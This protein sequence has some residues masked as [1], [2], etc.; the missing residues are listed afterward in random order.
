MSI[1]Q[2]LRD[3]YL[4]LTVV[5]VILALLGFLLMDS[6]NSN[7][8][9]IMG[10]GPGKIATVNGD[11]ITREE[12]EQGYANAEINYKEQN[13]DADMD[14]QTIEQLR[15]NVI[16]E[17]IRNKLLEEEY[18]KAD[19]QVSAAE[20]KY[21]MT[22]DNAS[23][24]LKQVPAFIN[25][26]T[27]QFDGNLVKEY[28]RNVNSKANPQVTEEDRRRWNEFKAS[29]LQERRMLKY[30]AL[31]AN[32]IYVPTYM[33]VDQ[34]QDAASVARAEL[35]TIPYD[36]IAAADIKV[37]DAEINE[38]I[39]NHKEQFRVRE[40]GRNAEYVMFK[41][42]PS[43]K[44]S[45]A[46]NTKMNTKLEAFKVASD[47]VAYINQN[48]SIPFT[49]EYK[50]AKDLDNPMIAGA[51][52]G[53]IVGPF[54]N[55]NMVT[56]SKIIATKQ[57]ADSANAQHILL[58]GKEGD[59][60]ES[61]QARADSIMG[62]IRSG[63]L[64]FGDAAAAF[65]SDES[66][67]AKAGDL[68]W[69]GRGMMVSQFEDST[70]AHSPGDMFTSLTQFGM[71]IIKLNE[72]KAYQTAYKV[73]NLSEFFEPSEETK[74]KINTQVNNFVKAA[75][76]PKNFDE[77]IKKQGLTKGIVQGATKS[78]NLVPSIGLSPVVNKWLFKHKKNDISEPLMIENGKIVMK[79]TSEM[80]KGYANA[81][82]VRAQVEPEIIKRKKADLVAKQNP[83]ITDLSALAAKYNTTVVTA[84][85]I[86]FAGAYSPQIGNELKVIGL[87]YQKAFKVGSISKPIPGNIGVIVVKKLSE[88]TKGESD[89]A[90]LPMVKKAMASRSQGQVI[91]NA[92]ATLYNKADVE[93]NHNQMF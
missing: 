29:L 6:I 85:S 64:S 65:S 37:T 70:F 33:A 52:V 16:S 50:T 79:I 78:S 83:N 30:N 12:Y 89:K 88:P 66:N 51:T 77:A 57:V 15:S 18:S 61:L 2:R 40:D 90:Q 32:S 48:S 86:R 21:Y 53:Q 73:G 4:G 58:A 23:G 24:Q 91:Q 92:I 82:D 54:Y 20:L 74:S 3:R 14:D 34:M 72:L 45:A 81:E 63:A 31:L 69:F 38:Y 68:G 46:F 27:G 56:Y 26:Q 67:K 84:D 80:K 17:I 28:D 55:K 39:K 71:H 22:S 49:D 59:T 36:S 19:I 47:P 25:R 13:P 75:N 43:P 35:V 93:D 1:I 9:S 8:N 41:E 44:D 60:R 7:P 76:N 87:V 11:E 10:G 42:V 62:Q 5:V